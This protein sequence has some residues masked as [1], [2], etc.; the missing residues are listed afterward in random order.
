MVGTTGSGTISERD[1]RFIVETVATQRSDHD[2]IIELV[3]DKPD[4]IEAMLNDEKLLQRVTSDGEILLRISPRLLF[5]ILIRGALRA[6]ERQAYTLERVGMEE[7]IPVFDSREVTGLMQDRQLRA[8][9]AEMLASF[10]RIGS[11]TVYFKTPRGYRRR[12]FSDIDLDDMMQ[13]SELLEREARFP[14]YKRIGDICLFITGMFPEHVS[15]RHA[16]TAAMPRPSGGKLRELEEYE[17][18]GV[19][20]YL[21][22]AEHAAGDSLSLAPTLGTLAENFSLARKPLNFISEKYVYLHKA[23]WFALDR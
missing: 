20:F 6:L 13:L 11:T 1:L 18:Y 14:F 21:L 2:Q 22:A 3:R 5:D 23:R 9:L 19:K 7:A 4:F 17:E 15:F 8:Y 10:T 16:A 12:T